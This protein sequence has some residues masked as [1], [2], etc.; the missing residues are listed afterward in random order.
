MNEDFINAFIENMNKKI[1]ELTRQEIMLSTRL[2]LAEKALQTSLKENLALQQENEKLATGLN[3]KV[4]KQNKE[5][6]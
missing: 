2:M 1:E 5:D 3:K 6:F 4:A